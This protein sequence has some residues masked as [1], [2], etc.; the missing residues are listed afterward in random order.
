MANS[1]RWTGF[2]K[3]DQISETWE[4]VSSELS[5]ELWMLM[6]EDE[7]FYETP[8]DALGQGPNVLSK[9][10]KNFSKEERK[11]LTELYKKNFGDDLD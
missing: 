7:K 3:L 11:T 6:E 8:G 10:W 5:R 9:H 4:G 2:F 1:P